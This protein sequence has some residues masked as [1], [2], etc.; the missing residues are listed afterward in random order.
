MYHRSRGGRASS[1]G[2]QLLQAFALLLRERHHP[3]LILFNS[4]IMLA[5]PR[6]IMASSHEMHKHQWNAQNDSA[7]K[8]A[9]LLLKGVACQPA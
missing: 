6:V 2:H 5:R 3:P 4:N 7:E 9:R 1:L 8:Y